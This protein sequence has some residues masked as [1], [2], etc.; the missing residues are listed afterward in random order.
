MNSR[1]AQN[2]TGRRHVAA[3]S[4]RLPCEGDREPAETSPLRAAFLRLRLTL[5]LSL[6]PS[7]GP[8]LTLRPGG[9]RLRLRRLWLLPRC[10]GSRPRRLRTRS[11]RLDARRD[12]TRVASPRFARPRHTLVEIPHLRLRVG[13]SRSLG[14]NAPA[15][16]FDLTTEVRR[17]GARGA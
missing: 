7:A 16:V 9:R 13:P 4:G 3:G 11:R 6:A 10:A 14:M 2:T 5:P 1:T 17:V 12:A 15:R 8:W